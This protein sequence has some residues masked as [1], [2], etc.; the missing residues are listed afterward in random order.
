M[1]P[2]R[3]STARLGMRFKRSRKAGPVKVGSHDLDRTFRQSLD[4]CLAVLFGQNPVVQ[5]YHNP[6]VGFCADQASD[7]LAE[8]ENGFREGEFAERVSSASFDGLD[9]GLDQRMIRH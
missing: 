1:R 9:A 2:Y 7:A 6:S 5:H 3:V 8:F 4:E